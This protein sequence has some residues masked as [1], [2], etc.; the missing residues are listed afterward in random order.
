MYE[1]IDSP[2][3]TG[4]FVCSNSLCGRV[5][6]SPLKAVLLKGNLPSRTYDACPHCLTEINSAQVSEIPSSIGNVQEAVL[7]Q[8][9]GP[10]AAP[11]CKHH[12]GFLN[13]RTS[14]DQ[15]PDECITCMDLVQC[16]LKKT[17]G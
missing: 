17:T 13:E 10:N 15:I 14:K 12:F 5:F 2:K 16:M 7:Q 9:E 11:H 8:S 1:T 4:G 3:K 6:D